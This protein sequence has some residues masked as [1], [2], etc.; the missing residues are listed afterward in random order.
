MFYNSAYNL[1]KRLSLIYC[2]KRQPLWV[3]SALNVLHVRAALAATRVVA[4]VAA[5]AFV[6]STTHDHNYAN[7]INL[8][9]IW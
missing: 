2:R 7:A 3:S 8:F 6:H 9:F 1:L 5:P 4:V